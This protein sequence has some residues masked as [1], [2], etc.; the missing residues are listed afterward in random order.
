[1]TPSSTRDHL[2]DYMEELVKYPSITHLHHFELF[3]DPYSERKEQGKKG[4]WRHD[5]SYGLRKA[6]R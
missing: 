6:I 3:G 5:K 1:M 4:N 2:E